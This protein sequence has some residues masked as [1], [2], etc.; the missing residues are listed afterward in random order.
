MA[1][2][3]LGVLLWCLT[4]LEVGV[5]IVHPE[6][7]DA[8]GSARGTAAP[9]EIVVALLLVL[10]VPGT[11]LIFLGRR[12]RQRAAAKFTHERCAVAGCNRAAV[13]S[14]A[15]CPLHGRMCSRIGQAFRRF[16]S[17]LEEMTQKALGA[18]LPP[19][20]DRA[21]EHRS[22]IGIDSLREV[23]PT[24]R[25]Q[26][27]PTPRTEV[28]AMQAPARSPRYSARY[29]VFISFK[30]L[31]S[32]GAPTRD[33]RLA[34]TV[35]EY[36]SSRGL[37]AFL[38]CISLEQLGV[39]AYKRAIDDALDAAH[40]LVAVGTTKENLDSEWVRYEWDSFFSDVLS[41]AKP[42][43]RIFAYVDGI[44]PVSL[45]RALRQT[46][47]ILHE[48]GALERLYNFIANATSRIDSS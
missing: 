10:G 43:G 19:V 37:R 44:D 6:R 34:R 11:L 32:D 35:Y 40:V 46:Q 7:F 30:N 21:A 48:D 14:S 12:S 13:A 22:V 45:P 42:Q 18:V 36:L 24:N 39:S 3:V 26:P 29:D 47:V 9:A 2:I 28:S 17:W 1:R 38:S 27:S 25:S 33:N 23:P 20:S 15:F 4:L 41:G 16:V 5:A 31:G 8:T